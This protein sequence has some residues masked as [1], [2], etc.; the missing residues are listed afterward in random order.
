MSAQKSAK[1]EP[2]RELPD[3]PNYPDTPLAPWIHYGITQ[4][5]GEEVQ[6][7]LDRLAYQGYLIGLR[8]AYTVADNT[9]MAYQ[10]SFGRVP[11]LQS[12]IVDTEDPLTDDFLL[13][14]HDAV[15]TLIH[16]YTPEMISDMDVE[17]T[18]NVSGS[19]HACSVKCL[20]GG[21]I[22]DK[23]HTGKRKCVQRQG[24]SWTCK[25]RTC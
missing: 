4:F 2:K 22:C 6:K 1:K 23:N 20:S 10:M 15:C 8:V 18:A 11:P 5:A 13:D 17:V 7:E 19:E 25:H 12:L 3:I 9:E 14:L 16:K 21:Y 24:G